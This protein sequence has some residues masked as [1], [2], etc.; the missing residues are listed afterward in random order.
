MTERT[1]RKE[2]KEQRKQKLLP[3]KLFLA[4]VQEKDQISEYIASDGQIHFLRSQ[5]KEAHLEGGCST[6]DF[7]IY[8]IM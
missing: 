4:N 8:I 5:C 7:S 3:K 1:D 2:S 6:P